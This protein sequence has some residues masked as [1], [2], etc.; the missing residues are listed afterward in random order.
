MMRSNS[1]SGKSSNNLRDPTMKDHEAARQKGDR[2]T[3]RA[4]LEP[5]E[6][7]GPDR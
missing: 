5:A 7:E 6:R 3:R 4:D 2:E 1:G